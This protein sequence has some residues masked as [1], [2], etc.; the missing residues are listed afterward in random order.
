M[1]TFWYYLTV[2]RT[3]IEEGDLFSSL[4]KPSCF[5]AQH[6]D[7]T[8]PPIKLGHIVIVTNLMTNSVHILSEGLGAPSQ[9]TSQWSCLNPYISKTIPTSSRCV[10]ICSTQIPTLSPFEFWCSYT[11]VFSGPLFFLVF[12][13]KATT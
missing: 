10:T 13:H 8:L 9:K 12:H 11:A 1:K 3:Q 7:A 5:G 6:P 2:S 4:L